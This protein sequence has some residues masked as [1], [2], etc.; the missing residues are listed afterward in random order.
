METQREILNVGCGNQPTGDINVDRYVDDRSHSYQPGRTA[1]SRSLRTFKIPNF[2][3]ADGHRLPFPDDSFRIVHCYNVM[4]HKGVDP[5]RLIRELLRV[6]RLYVEF[7]VP[8]FWNWRH[9]PKR[10]KSHARVFRE[11]HLTRMFY[12]WPCKIVPIEFGSLTPF[13]PLP[14]VPSLY[15]VRVWKSTR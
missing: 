10:N 8:S 9:N 6:C 11:R 14:L 4:E 2:I 13:F 12:E 3:Q 15:Q 1:Y 7:S 5:R